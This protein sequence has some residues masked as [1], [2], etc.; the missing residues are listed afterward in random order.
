MT[1]FIG[2]LQLAI[3][4]YVHHLSEALKKSTNTF[5]YLQISSFRLCTNFLFI[6]PSMNIQT[7]LSSRV[8]QIQ[9]YHLSSKALE[10]RQMYTYM[11]KSNFHF[12]KIIAIIYQAPGT[13]LSIFQTSFFFLKP[14]KILEYGCYYLYFY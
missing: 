12:T 9:F 4:V 8:F 13:L 6:S 10:Q 2:H 14:Y 11:Q 3:L 1:L 5:Y 7:V